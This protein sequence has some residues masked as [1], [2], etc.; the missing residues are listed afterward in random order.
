MSKTTS[1]KHVVYNAIEAILQEASE[2]GLAFT[3]VEYDSDGLLN[4]VID[5]ETGMMWLRSRLL[6]LSKK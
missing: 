6:E 1:N 2:H 5:R 3:E 4:P